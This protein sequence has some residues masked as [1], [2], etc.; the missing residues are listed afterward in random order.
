MWKLGLTGSIA[1]GKS[2][3][4]AA[5]A[6]LGVP[7][8]SSDEA[9]HELY[10]GEAVPVV[11]QLF[12]GVTK[13]GAIDRVELSKRVLGHPEKLKALESAVHPLVRA[14]IAKFLA[15]A[16]STGAAL[17]IVDIPLL[18]EGGHDYGLDRVAVTIA[19]DETIR[20]RALARPG[21]SVDKLDAILARQMPQAEKR[22]RADYLL[23][24]ERSVAATKAAVKALV[25]ALR[26]APQGLPKGS[27]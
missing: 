18:F 11:E 5:F 2:T 7:V 13:D 22:K 23:Y 9:V 10:Q 16:E 20:K 12:P 24:T 21:M 8:F 14:R 4:L 15:D 27:Q 1:S 19:E 17:A 26:A 3:A 25:E 6:E